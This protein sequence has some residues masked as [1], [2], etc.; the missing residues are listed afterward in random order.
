M[1]QT[2]WIERHRPQSLDD[3]HGQI[4]V[5]RSLKIFLHKKDF[6]HM[7]FT[8][9]AGTGKTSSAYAFISDLAKKY[10][11]SLDMIG[12]QIM[13]KNASDEMRMED[14]DTLSAFVFHGSPIITF[15]FKFIILDESDNLS[16][17][18]QSALRRIIEGAPSTVKFILMNNEV[19]K[20][21]DP[22]LSRCA[23]F[24]FYPV[25][26]NHAIQLMKKVLEIEKITL[27]DT[28]LELVYGIVHGDLRTAINV[29]QCVVNL[30][31]DHV[32]TEEQISTFF[33]MLK[34]S[35]LDAFIMAMQTKDTTKLKEFLN[36]IKSVSMRHFLLQI[37]ATI[38]QFPPNFQALL[39]I[40]TAEIDYRSTLGAND[41][42]QIH[43][44]CGYFLDILDKKI[45][46][47]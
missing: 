16:R 35:H 30:T 18:V 9:H 7:I 2:L 34:K 46:E 13:E 3:V 14:I 28:I 29:L 19:E 8:G 11:T 17:E 25:S 4:S 37:F 22:I 27:S 21:I 26:K 15:P 39:T 20:L 32:I 12:E 10:G 42:I 1:E 41:L 24:R 6:P 47:V 33:G 43:A 45:Q 31:K 40:A 36:Q 38:D 23:I 5:V 44:L